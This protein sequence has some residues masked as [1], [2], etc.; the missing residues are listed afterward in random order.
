[1]SKC[2]SFV[3]FIT[4]L[5][6]GKGGITAMST[7]LASV[8]EVNCASSVAKATADLRSVF[9][10]QLPAMIGFRTDIDNDDTERLVARPLYDPARNALEDTKNT[11]TTITNEE[12]ML[13]IVLFVNLFICNNSGKNCRS[14]SISTQATCT[15]C[16]YNASTSSD[17]TAMLSGIIE[18]SLG[19][20]LV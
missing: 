4:S 15:I 1:M 17:I 19:Y 13:Y 5:M 3:T 18:S 9:I 8:A 11:A 7:L 16:P 2:L 10:F 6:K 12:N 14:E 20:D